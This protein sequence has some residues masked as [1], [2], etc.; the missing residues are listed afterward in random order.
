MPTL[1]EHALCEL[2]RNRPELALELLAHLSLKLPDHDAIQIER[3]ALTQDASLDNGSLVLSLRTDKPTLGIIVE[4]QLQQ[5]TN[6]RYEWPYY[7]SALRARLRCPV[8]LVVVTTKRSV[9]RWA[10]TPIRLGGGNLFQAT[11]IGPAAIPAV[12]EQ[13]RA[14]KLPELAVLSALAHGRGLDLER[15]AK[16][17]DAAIHAS[18]QLEPERRGLYVEVVLNSLSDAARRL[19][20]AIDTKNSIQTSTFKRQES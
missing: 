19:L 20:E 1:T 6:K 12:T 7:V 5:D 11:V 9:A 15:A 4:A 13:H 14:A 17:A 8:M 18:E 16:I 2:F 10:A 3:A